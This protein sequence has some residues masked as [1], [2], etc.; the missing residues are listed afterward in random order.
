MIATVFMCALMCDV[1]VAVCQP[2]VKRIY[3]LLYD[4]DIKVIPK[5]ISSKPTLIHHLLFLPISTIESRVS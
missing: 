5:S 2:S 1:W 3:L 4:A